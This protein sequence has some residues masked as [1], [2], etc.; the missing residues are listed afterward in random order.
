M[1]RV[2]TAYRRDLGGH[3]THV[4]ATTFAAVQKEIQ[5]KRVSELN[6]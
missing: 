4:P 2:M 5:E 1:L 6:Q 3:Q